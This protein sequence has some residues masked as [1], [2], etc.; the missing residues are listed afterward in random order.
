MDKPQGEVKVGCVEEDGFWKFR[1]ADN[2]PGIEEEHFER[3]FR[4]FQTLKPR[5]KFESTGIGLTVVK[6]IVESYGGRIWVESKLGEGSV[7]YF[8]LPKQETQVSN[9]K[10]EVGVSN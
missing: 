5:D 8:T 1:V 7:F 4:M 2:G 10:V 6:K 9:V 3:I